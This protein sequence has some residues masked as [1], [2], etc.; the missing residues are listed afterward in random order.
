M[1]FELFDLLGIN[2]F[3]SLLYLSVEYKD[4]Y[5]LGVAFKRDSRMSV[6][7]SSDFLSSYNYGFE[8]VQNIVQ[9][10]SLHEN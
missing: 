1:I 2:P 6:R 4:L 7:V 8:L 5:S 3:N 9:F 10:N